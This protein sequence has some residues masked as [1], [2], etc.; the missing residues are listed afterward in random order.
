M[1]W[2]NHV[3]PETEKL[4]LDW[5]R[6]DKEPFKKL[7]VLR[8]MR[9]DRLQVALQHFVVETLP[10]GKDFVMC[11]ATMNSTGILDSTLSDA[12]PTT[13]IFFILS[14]GADVVGDVEALAQK[15]GFEKGVSY[16]NVAMGQGQ[17]VIAMEALELAS[18]QGHWVLLNNVH[19]MPRWLIELEKKLD[20]FAQEGSHE[21]FRVFLTGEPSSSIPIGML[22]RSIKLTNEPPSGLKANLIRAFCSF[23]PEFVNE[24]E[25]KTRAILFGLCHFHA[26]LIER[27]KFGP[28]GY[29]IMYPFSLGDLRDSSVCLTNYMENASS[30]IPWEDLR[31]IFG[32]IMYGGHIV[33]DFD[34]LL[35]GSYLN[36][37]LK[38]VWVVRVCCCWVFSPA[39]VVVVVGW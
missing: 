15:Y 38:Y 24:V 22:N 16:H 35:C 5:A 25:P 31:Y 27:K 23:S 6:L 11:D 10:Q 17:D 18:K 1:E 13:P 3:T 19:L 28:I 12:T 21:R 29:N 37:F 2:F 7:L 4:P 33:N 30:K 8:C 36:H 9:P 34:R 39:P 26:I 32:Q 14:P 20:V